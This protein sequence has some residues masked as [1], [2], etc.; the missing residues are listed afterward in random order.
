MSEIK[1]SDIFVDTA[2][3]GC[4]IDKHQPFHQLAT[5]IY[6]E[7]KQQHG[8]FIT[9]NYVITEL[10]ALCIS[11]LN[12]SRSTSL[13]FISSIKSTS[14]IQVIHLDKSLDELA[15]QLLLNRTDKNWSL[16]DCSSF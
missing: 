10:V 1:K 14:H 6:F 3:W 2:G 12:I 11:R 5:Q 16:V 13:E 7:V 4:L 15:W 8:Q 9:T